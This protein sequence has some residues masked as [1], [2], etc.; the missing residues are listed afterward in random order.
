LSL[1]EIKIF[2]RNATFEGHLQPLRKRE[3]IQ[4]QHS[5]EK[6]MQVCRSSKFTAVAHSAH[7]EAPHCSATLHWAAATIQGIT[8]RATPTAMQAVLLPEATQLRSGAAIQPTTQET[9]SL[10]SGLRVSPAPCQPGSRWAVLSDITGTCC[11]K[12]KPYC[13]TAGVAVHGRSCLTHSVLRCALPVCLLQCLTHAID[14]AG[15]LPQV[16]QL[17]LAG[18]LSQAA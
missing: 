8:C 3:C 11:V 17:Q 6:K 15:P 14:L 4:H 7:A 16:S 1:N 18:Q 10:S 9:C 12:A 5:R 2:S 13:A